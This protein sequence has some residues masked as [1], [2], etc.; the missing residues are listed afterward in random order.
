MFLR[1]DWVR[2]GKWAFLFGLLVVLSACGGG[3]GDSGSNVSNTV[4]PAKVKSTFNGSV[5][6]GPVVASVITFTDVDGKDVHTAFSD[7]SANYEAAVELEKSAYPLIISAKAGTDLVTDLPPDFELVSLVLDSD[8]SRI[9]INPFTTLIVRTAQHMGGVSPN[10]I[11]KAKNIVLKEMGFGLDTDLV[12]DPF[13][14]NIDEQNISVMVKASEMLGE[15]VRRA[16]DALLATGEQV[17]GDQIIDT[18]AADLVDQVLDGKGDTTADPRT[19]AVVSM[20]SG[21]VLVEALSNHLYVHGADA[22]LKMDLAIQ[23]SL[24]GGAGRMPATREVTVTAGLVQQ[25]RVA[26]DAAIAYSPS[27][28]LKTIRLALDGVSPGD[29][30][31]SLEAVI[32][33]AGSDAFRQLLSALA[34]ASMSEIDQVNQ[35]RR[36]TVLSAASSNRAPTIQ[37]TPASQV[38]QGASYRF[39]PVSVDMDN[40]PL[41]F[42]ISNKPAWASF[43]VGTGVLS[44]TPGNANVGTFR[45]IVI[46]VSDGTATA[47]LPAFDVQVINV[48]DAPTIGGSPSANATVGTPYRFAPS[49]SDPDPGDSLSF[50]VANKPA[51]ANFD[52]ATGVLSGTPST[53]QTGTFS[54]IGISVSDGV[55]RVALP[56]FS[57]TVKLAGGSISNR[58]PLISGQP[59][60]SVLQGGTYRFQPQASDADGDKLVFSI[61]GKPTWA[62]FNPATGVLTGQPGNA[63]VGTTRSVVL[64]VSDG[65]VSTALPA[66]DVRVVNVNDAPVISG[67]PAATIIQDAQ[68]LFAPTA[69]DIDGDTLTFTIINKPVWASFNVA[70]G[71]LSGTPTSNDVGTSTGIVIRVSDGTASVALP[72]FDI[73]VTAVQ[74]PTT[75]DLV[76]SASSTRSSPATLAG[77]TVSGTVYVFTSV[78]TGIARVDFFLDNPAATGQPRQTEF[79]APFDFANIP[80]GFDSLSVADGAHSITATVTFNNG[81]VS[82][83]QADFTVDNASSSKATPVANSDQATAVAGQPVVIDVLANDAGL[84]NTPVVVQVT[85]LPANGSVSVAADNTITYTA[86]QGYS[87]QDGF[88]YRVTDANGDSAIASVTLS[89]S[90]TGCTV[91]SSLSLA[92]P[93]NLDAV[94]GYRIYSG[95]S[96]SLVQTRISDLSAATPGFNMQTPSVSYD[97]V[98]D[99]G[100]SPGDYMCFQIRAYNAAGESASSDASCVQL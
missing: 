21:E 51:W 8:Q 95:P 47:S 76:M 99:L 83:V 11:Q 98:K 36:D 48:N 90:C 71:V 22:T 15:V 84:A 12:K 92:W 38:R 40:D 28:E 35:M 14:A 20:T 73:K 60:T 6:D 75:V 70:N 65:K 66:F 79:K 13:Y 33:A 37:G 96:I 1:S 61:S 24:S 54:G 78:E 59:G 62:S 17:D 41:T 10:N 57:V 34:S 39:A 46:A 74:A 100:A 3:N 63:D 29:T 27:V 31:A 68:Y 55:S 67:S 88:L 56:V 58:A 69:S 86:A 49:A 45:S 82:V 64:S 19:A 44:G 97:L 94:D 23:Q 43:D 9:N 42:S 89:V 77:A 87:G 72:S 4:A 81:A 30:A 85:S 52:P 25:L 32:P 93:A 50:S 18:I 7:S 91:A 53:N 26:L 16:R 5:G 80:G 2:N